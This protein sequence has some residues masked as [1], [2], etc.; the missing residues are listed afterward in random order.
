MTLSSIVVAG[1]ILF[2][3]WQLFKPNDTD[4]PQKRT[5]SAIA[6]HCE[7]DDWY[8]SDRRSFSDSSGSLNG[9]G[10]WGETT[11]KICGKHGGWNH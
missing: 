11:C 4:E 1:I 9:G 3:L 10:S 2:V 6:P 8:I 7:H 5:R